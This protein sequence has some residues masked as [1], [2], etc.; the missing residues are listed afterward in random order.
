[1]LNIIMDRGAGFT[2]IELVVVIVVI[3]VL[4]T[5]SVVTPLN[6]M[7]TARDTERADDIASIAR[8]LEQ[9]YREQTVGAPAYP[10]MDEFVSDSATQT[11]TATGAS[12]A[13]YEAPGATA[14]SLV[15][16]TQKSATDPLGSG[17]V[18]LNEYVYQALQD[19]GNLCK[20][21]GQTCVSY[22]LFYCQESSNDFLP[23]IES[24]HQQ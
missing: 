18:P 22:R 24:L 3:G 9:D 19:N 17:T 12:A 13:A 7:V 23:P 11:G 8:V 1:M 21:V 2:V 15:P 10:P 16:A 4:L 14:S 20:T 5:I 6:L